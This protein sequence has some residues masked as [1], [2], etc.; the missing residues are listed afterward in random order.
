MRPCS[1][2]QSPAISA[3]VLQNPVQRDTAFAWFIR[4]GYRASIR[5]VAN[6]DIR[7]KPGRD[8]RSWARVMVTASVN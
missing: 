7:A 3:H 2:L 4:D 8:L 1:H 6:A 5:G